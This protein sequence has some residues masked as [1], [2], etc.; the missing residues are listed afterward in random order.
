MSKTRPFTLTTIQQ[1]PD[2]IALPP[3]ER[4]CI[5]KLFESKQ[6]NDTGNLTRPRNAFFI[7]RPTRSAEILN[8]Y[9]ATHG[10]NLAQKDISA[11]I[12]QEWGAMSP[13]DK[14]VYELLAKAEAEERRVRFPNYDYTPVPDVWWN[15]LTKDGKR[16]FFFESLVRICKTMVYSDY[17]WPGY[18]SIQQWAQDPRNAAYVDQ[19]KLRGILA[20]GDRPV[21]TARHASRGSG[22]RPTAPARPH[23]AAPHPYNA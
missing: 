14:G 19:V 17:R 3:P 18:T 12:K 10:S 23:R 6:V 1:Y 21:A 13:Q 4:A 5:C 2:F 16:R 22:S 15:A 8:E 20:S 9:Q 11:Q 7:F